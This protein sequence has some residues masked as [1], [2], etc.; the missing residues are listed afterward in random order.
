MKT[1]LHFLPGNKH[2]GISYQ[3]LDVCSV[4]EEKNSYRNV[5]VTPNEEGDYVDK[6]SE[7]G[8][9]VC[10]LPYSIPKYFDDLSAV[11][12]NVRW[13]LTFFPS[14]IKIRQA[15]RRHDADI[16][17]LNGL[18][19]LQPAFAAALSDVDVVWYLV[20]DNM[21]PDWLVRAV[22]PFVNNISSEVVLISE[23]NREFYRQEDRDVSI[24][25]GGV[26]VES[27]VDKDVSQEQV[28][29]FWDTYDID[30]D[31]PTVITLAKVHPM[32]GQHYAVDALSELRE[33]VNYLVVGPILD[34]EYAEQLHQTASKHG[35]SDQLYVTGFVE[36]KFAAL[37]GADVFL[38]PSM[39]EGT[40]LSIMEASML[41]LPVIASDVG[42]VSELLGDGAGGQ[43][44]P[45]RD[46]SAI[47]EAIQ[48]YLNDPDLITEHTETVYS[49]VRS[50]YSIKNI[51]QSYEQ[52]YAQL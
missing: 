8:L 11:L 21:Y 10:Q 36:D 44:V 7:Q 46:S 12:S 34:A 43:L 9:D 30:P 52:V 39:G 51:A 19:L 18:L 6:V 25:P 49:L 33:E 14:I 38:L 24:I 20:S 48:R 27:I 37:A 42:G 32:K 17:H 2:G 13:A 3:V 35:V 23:S 16:V 5:I 26:D 45:P 41:E 1:I 29:E 50:K 15:I 28:N 31:K 22:I 40:P 47:S 4:L